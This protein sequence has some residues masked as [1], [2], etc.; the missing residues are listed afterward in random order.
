MPSWEGLKAFLK[1]G[2]PDNFSLKDLPPDGPGSKRTETSPWVIVD[3]AW[4]MVVDP[5]TD[6]VVEATLDASRTSAYVILASLWNIFA[7]GTGWAMLS[8]INEK[9]EELDPFLRPPI[10]LVA[11]NQSGFFSNT[12]RSRTISFSIFEG[13]DPLS[14]TS[15]V[16]DVFE[17]SFVPMSVN[18]A[19]V[20]WFVQ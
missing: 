5:I 20:N 8:M 17:D 16:F 1:A 15:S 3:A 10:T 12:V 7:G 6:P 18:R 14:L 4:D 9:H 13:S 19:V 2:V 11:T